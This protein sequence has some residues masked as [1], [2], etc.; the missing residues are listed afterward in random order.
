ML[1]CILVTTIVFLGL[2]T[3]HLKLPENR[4]SNQPCLQLGTG[5]CV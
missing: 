2:P 1:K 5:K 3:F 4:Q